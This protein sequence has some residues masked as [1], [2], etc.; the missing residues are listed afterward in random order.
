MSFNSIISNALGTIASI[1]GVVATYSRGN[2][3]C[4]L[5]AVPL[6][7]VSSAVDE[8]GV[9]VESRRQDFSLNASVLKF[10]T[11]AIEPKRGD[12]IEITANGR[13]STYTVGR[14]GAKRPWDFIDAGQTRYRVRT[15]LTQV[16]AA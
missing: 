16:E 1:A 15:T 14:D 9:I 3:S 6:T 8:S 10:G 7:D 13:T 4:S 11:Q 2:Q 5:I 12:K